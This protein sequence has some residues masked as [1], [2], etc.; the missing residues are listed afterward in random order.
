MK[1]Y[2]YLSLLTDLV[3][4][5]KAPLIKEPVKD[6]C[7]DSEDYLFGAYLRYVG[8]KEKYPVAEFVSGPYGASVLIDGIE[9]YRLELLY[10][11]P[12]PVEVE[13]D[14]LGAEI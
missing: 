5:D 14:E 8:I 2:Y 10:I 9:V 12:T 3:R 6:L 4:T 1:A 11:E 7:T 13:E